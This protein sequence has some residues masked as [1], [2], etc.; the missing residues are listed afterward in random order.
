MPFRTNTEQ[1]LENESFELDL[2][3]PLIQRVSIV[4]CHSASRITWHSHKFYELL[5][6]SE[7]ATAY[8]FRDGVTAELTGGQFLIIPPD[9]VHRGLNDLR[10]P[11][12]L[13][14][15]M[16]APTAPSAS[17]H[18]PFSKDDLAWLKQRL[19]LAALKPLKMNSELRAQVK[20]LPRKIETFSADT[21][22]T[23]LRTR[24]TMCQLLFEVVTHVDSP[25]AVPSTTLVERAIQYMQNHLHDP[26]SMVKVAHA[27]GCSRA[28]LFETF[29]ETTGMTPNDYWQRM[30]V[31]EAYQRLIQ[32]SDPITQVAMDCGFTTS[33]YF[34]TVFRK[35]WGVSPREC[36][37][38]IKIVEPAEAK[39]RVWL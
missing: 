38:G 10:K 20:T 34:C 17:Q 1:V 13:C 8:E 35:Y 14:G 36:R 39:P 33:Q 24:L 16:I 29:K 26:T 3:I 11:G 25:T 30:R 31:E 6:L 28:R 22:Q 37:K 12:S 23:V 9:V 2:G 27:V 5:L 7:G 18:T 32:T 4:R 21:V 15:V 19:D